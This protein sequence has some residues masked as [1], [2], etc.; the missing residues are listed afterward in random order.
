MK[1]E[2]STSADNTS[3]TTINRGGTRGCG[4]GGVLTDVA[5]V[6]SQTCKNCERN[7]FGPICCWMN[8][9]KS[10]ESWRSFNAAKLKEFMD[11]KNN[12]SID[13]FAM[14]SM[15][16]LSPGLYDY[17]ESLLPSP[18][19][20][21][22]A[23]IGDDLTIWDNGAGCHLIHA[24]TASVDI[25]TYWLHQEALAGRIHDIYTSTNEMIVKGLTKVFPLRGFNEFV[26]MSN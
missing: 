11:R 4:R 18:D 10:P 3:T 5:V 23:D 12:F 21:T 19:D 16:D 9:D 14:A 7:H 22:V 1:P 6:V 25:H 24:K 2:T 17:G 26:H 20:I 15:A 13:E 8:S